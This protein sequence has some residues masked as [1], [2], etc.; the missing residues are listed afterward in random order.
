MQIWIALLRGVN[1]G[2]VNKLPMKALVDELKSI[3]LMEVK[4]YIQSGN[5]VF[6]DPDIETVVLA[7][8]LGMLIKSKFG[9]EPKVKIISYQDLLLAI[10]ANPFVELMNDTAGKNLHFFFLS[11]KPQDYCQNFLDQLCLQNEQWYLQKDV[12][13]LVTPKGFSNSKVP[14]R[15]EKI[16]GVDATSRNWHTVE[17]L[18][19]L[20]ADLYL[21]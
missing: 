5:I 3:G 4:T 6:Y 10:Q 13:Y 1:V 16:L 7:S 20:G 21:Q 19:R 18:V 17:A 14:S 8:Q 15:V 9:F 11:N 2:G 12:F